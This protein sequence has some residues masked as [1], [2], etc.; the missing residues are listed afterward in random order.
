MSAAKTLKIWMADQRVFTIA[1]LVGAAGCDN[2]TARKAVKRC[3]LRPIKWEKRQG[4]WCGHYCS[5][6]EH[7]ER[8]TPM[9]HRKVMPVVIS[10][11]GEPPPVPE[12]HGSMWFLLNIAA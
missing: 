9:I 11:K 1:D 5:V 7:V 2:S 3:G 10:T 4:G 6:G 8:P 12:G